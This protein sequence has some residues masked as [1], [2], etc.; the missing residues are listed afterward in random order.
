MIQI[1]ITNQQSIASINPAP[2]IR[3]LNDVFMAEGFS[4]GEVSVALVD[5]AKI[6][7]VNRRFLEHDFPTDVISFRLDEPDLPDP[8]SGM[9][10]LPSSLEGEIVVSVETAARMAPENSWCIESE[11]L[12]YCLHGALH[13]C[14][15]DDLTAGDAQRMRARE[16]HYLAPLGLNPIVQ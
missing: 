11:V 5:D 6:H 13:L 15:F 1:E 14:G 8:D 4:T 2:L 12:L 3:L 10:D 16:T 9:P 7:E